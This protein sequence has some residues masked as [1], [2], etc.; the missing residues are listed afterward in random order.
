MRKLLPGSVALIAAGLCGMSV[1]AL[2]ADLGIG[3]PSYKSPV[4]IMHAYDWTGFYVGG[5]A[6]GHWGSDKIIEGSGG[7]FGI[8]VDANW[9]GGTA[10]RT[11]TNISGINASDQMTNSVQGSFLTTLRMRWGTTVISDRSLL[12][13]TAGFAFETMKTNDTMSHHNPLGVVTS[14]SGSTTEPGWVAGGGF[15]YAIT[16]Y[17]SAKAE[18]LYIAI[19]DVNTTIP[20]TGSFAD[21]IAVTHSYTEQVARFGLNLKLSN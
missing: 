15:E 13:I 12:F 14:V 1:P 4:P 9:L 10:S 18:Y 11:L 3:A 19:K 20:S 17:R 2:A 6:G 5:N 8:E 16:D 7:V 21:S